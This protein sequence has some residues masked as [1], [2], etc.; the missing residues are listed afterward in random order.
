MTE[1]AIAEARD[2]VAD[3]TNDIGDY[4]LKSRTQGPRARYPNGNP[5]HVGESGVRAARLSG[6]GLT[7]TRPMNAAESGALLA[8]LHACWPN[9]PFDASSISGEAPHD[10]KL[11]AALRPLG[12]AVRKTG[13]VARLRLRDAQKI[14]RWFDEVEGC[15][16]GSLVLTRDRYGWCFVGD[17]ETWARG[18]TADPGRPR[19]AAADAAE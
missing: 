12:V 8:A 14:R 5:R 9:R 4:T 15:E 17:R 6:L 11:L 18:N 7:P 10:P 3:K 19:K 1:I 13:V 16:L 2:I